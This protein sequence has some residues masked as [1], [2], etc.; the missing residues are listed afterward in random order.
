MG[1]VDFETFH[2]IPMPTQMPSDAELEESIKQWLMEPNP[3]S[4]FCPNTTIEDLSL[5]MLEGFFD[6]PNSNPLPMDLDEGI[7]D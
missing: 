6:P 5:D 4:L 2:S 1:P 7:F 3:A